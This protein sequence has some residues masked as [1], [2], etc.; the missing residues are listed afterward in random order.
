MKHSVLSFLFAVFTSAAL[1]ACMDYPRDSEG[2]LYQDQRA[3][4]KYHSESKSNGTRGFEACLW[5]ETEEEVSIDIEDVVEC[6]Y[7]YGAD[8]PNPRGYDF[9]TGENDYD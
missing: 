3:L 2:R 7:K 1:A 9:N 4:A 8:A 6:S 5:K